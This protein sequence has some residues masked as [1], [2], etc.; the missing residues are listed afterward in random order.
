MPGRKNQPLKA[1]RYF[2]RVS[3]H[4]RP[5]RL[6]PRRRAGAYLS[7]AR[8]RH[9]PPA[10]FDTAGKPAAR[11]STVAPN[12]AVASSAAERADDAAASSP[13]VGIVAGSCPCEGPGSDAGASG[14]AGVSDSPGSSGSPGPSGSSVP[15]GLAGSVGPPGFSG[16]VGSPG[17]SGFS[18][19]PGS[20]APPGSPGFSGS[21][22][23]SGSS[24]VSSRDTVSALRHTLVT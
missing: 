21:S 10:F 13:V 2:T 7:D 22:G 20:S 18:G 15:P 3:L 14:S 12:P 8:P 23:S 4:S 6:P 9:R 16:S 19:S 11:P 17:P 24:G 5:D 1:F